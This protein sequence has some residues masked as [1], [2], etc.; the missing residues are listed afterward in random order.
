MRLLIIL[1]WALSTYAD[2]SIILSATVGASLAHTII[3]QQFATSLTPRFVTQDEQ[4]A[5]QAELT[6]P[7]PVR[8][9]LEEPKKQPFAIDYGK[10]GIMNQL[11]QVTLDLLQYPILSGLYTAFNDKIDFTPPQKRIQVSLDVNRRELKLSYSF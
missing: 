5:L 4:T 3:D 9:L 7:E 1:F 6:L 10:S 11:E 2:E 8:L